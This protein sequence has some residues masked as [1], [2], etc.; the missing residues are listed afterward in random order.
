M[1]T[2]MAPSAA[3]PAAKMSSHNETMQKHIWAAVGATGFAIILSAVVAFNNVDAAAAKPSIP[4]G[5]NQA[6]TKSD[7]ERVMQR[8]GKIDRALE[9]IRALIS[10]TAP[11]GE[12]PKRDESYGMPGKPPVD[13][14]AAPAGEGATR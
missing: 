8:L 13:P 10:P 9:E 14:A 11:Q 2:K 7:V 5:G 1:K 3:K 4:Q 12:A 6:A